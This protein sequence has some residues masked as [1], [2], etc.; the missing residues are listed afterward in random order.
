MWP[1]DNPE[2]YGFGLRDKIDSIAHRHFPL[3]QIAHLLVCVQDLR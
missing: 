2:R 3:N 1:F